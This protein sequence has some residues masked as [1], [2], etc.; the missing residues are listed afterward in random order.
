ML[1]V[2]PKDLLNRAGKLAPVGRRGVRGRLVPRPVLPAWRTCRLT[3]S[4]ACFFAILGAWVGGLAILLAV[5]LTFR[6]S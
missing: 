6:W 1:N 2:R 5:A 3:M 4:R